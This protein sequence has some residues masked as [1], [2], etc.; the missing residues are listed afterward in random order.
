MFWAPSLFALLQRVHFLVDT[1]TDSENWK[2]FHRHH[3]IVTVT[4]AGMKGA[5]DTYWAGKLGG[6]DT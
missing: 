4:S 1:A 3:T 6:L 2:T 5:A